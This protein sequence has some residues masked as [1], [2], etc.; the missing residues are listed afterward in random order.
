MTQYFNTKCAKRF[1]RRWG[2]ATFEYMMDNI[3]SEV[4]GDMGLTLLN[5]NMVSTQHGTLVNNNH[6][7]CSNIRNAFVL[8]ASVIFVFQYYLVILLN[9]KNGFS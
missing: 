3:H 2:H 1:C 8:K 7:S 5:G 9:L 4:A 6:K